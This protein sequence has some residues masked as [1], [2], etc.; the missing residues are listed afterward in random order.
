VYDKRTERVHRA[1]EA[2][3]RAGRSGDV[4]LQENRITQFYTAKGAPE[5]MRVEV[6]GQRLLGKQLNE[7]KTLSNRF[8]WFHFADLYS[9]GSDL[10][11]LL[12]QAFT[13]MC[14]DIGVTAALAAF[15]GGNKIRKVNAFWRSRQSTWWQPENM[16]NQVEGLLRATDLFP[17][18]AFDEPQ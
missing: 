16:W 14:R 5:R 4:S 12:Q 11:P 17:P 18:E 1:V 6:R 8:A 10:P 7:I 15:K 3:V 9:E 13:S 2:L